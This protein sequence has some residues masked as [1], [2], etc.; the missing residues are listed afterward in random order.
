MDGDG[1]HETSRRREERSE[2]RRVLGL[3]VAGFQSM[4]S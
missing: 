4:D 2:L 3:E 1:R